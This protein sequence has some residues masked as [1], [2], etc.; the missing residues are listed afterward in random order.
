[1]ATSFIHKQPGY[2]VA[3]DVFHN[4]KKN[5]CAIV[6]GATG[7]GKT[8]GILARALD[9]YKQVIG[10]QP[11]IM[12]TSMVAHT[13]A[14]FSMEPIGHRVGF[15]TSSIRC[16]D[17]GDELSQ[18]FIATDGLI[19]DQYLKNRQRFD[20]E[21]TLIVLDEQH[22]R[23]INMDVL[24]CLFLHPRYGLK[25][26]HFI[27][28]S[29]TADV[30]SLEGY[31]S[32]FN[33]AVKTFEVLGRPHDLHFE[34]MPASKYMDCICQNIALNR[35]VLAFRP[36]R[37]EVENTAEEIRK[38]YGDKVTVHELYADLSR[39]EQERALAP[40]PEGKQK[41]IVSTNVAQTS[42][43]IPHIE[44]VVMDGKVLRHHYRN[45]CNGVE[46]V[47]LSQSAIMQQAGRVGRTQKGYSYL[48]SDISFKERPEFEKPPIQRSELTTVALKLLGAGIRFDDLLLPSPPNQDLV[49]AAL[50]EL[51]TLG[52]INAEEHVTAVGR[53]MLEY[54]VNAPFSRMLA[55]ADE[56]N[57][58]DF[59][60]PL[61]AL[62]SAQSL[63][64]REH[65]RWER[66]PLSNGSDFIAQAELLLEAL[67][68]AE[69]KDD[70]ER[71]LIYE[72][73]GLV[74]R[75]V[76]RARDLYFTLC[77]RK[78]RPILSSLKMT[79]EQTK[80]IYASISA[81]FGHHLCEVHLNKETNAKFLHHIGLNKPLRL[82][83]HSSLSLNVNDKVIGMPFYVDMD[84][85][86]RYELSWASLSYDC[87]F[88][89]TEE[90]THEEKPSRR[91]V[92]KCKKDKPEF[93]GKKASHR[94]RLNDRS[95]I[96]S[97]ETAT[98]VS[99]G[100]NLTVEEVV[101]RH[102]KKR[103]KQKRA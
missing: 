32:S 88:K 62:N 98:L 53:K 10:L 19:L 36:T 20:K 44:A 39:I 22:E 72:D 7:S 55:E 25:K 42:I 37:K 5:R 96:E 101:E 46:L 86:V 50:S 66:E 70:E 30:S 85:S 12:P 95:N 48:C 64:D 80:S 93:S 79:K 102:H 52:A 17:E 83:Q 35:S 43:T 28:M 16:I 100:Q 59:A 76:E 34:E 67:R 91:I 27:V 9:A 31:F 40:C 58:L 24:L 26:A 71:E 4:M 47:N 84:E 63:I 51:K 1:M 87:L 49:N 13:L 103:P 97:I 57:V 61:A 92:R 94:R 29:A 74:A 6:V 2:K 68:K 81:G 33:K 69:D 23:N 60:L 54:P 41:V 77:E 11:R 65:E 3:K 45:N 73:M 18:C 8:L 75:R 14:E 15:R 89:T 99:P 56:L 82:S 38:T 90:N 78:E 21:G